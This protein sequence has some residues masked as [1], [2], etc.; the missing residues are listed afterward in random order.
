[1]KTVTVSFV[2]RYL[3]GLVLSTGLFFAINLPQPIHDCDDCFAPHG[4]PFTYYHEGGYGGGAGY[5][6]PGI[7]A[8]LG[9]VLLA[10]F[11]IEMALKIIVST[12]RNR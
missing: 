5:V 4:R 2:V 11:L 12:K 10:A 1:M 6:W 7:I 3:A 8:D 9:I